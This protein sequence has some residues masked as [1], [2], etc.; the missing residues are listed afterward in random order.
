M[1][2]TVRKE[3]GTVIPFRKHVRLVVNKENQ[4]RAVQAQRRD[5]R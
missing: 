3:D 2:I 5:K 1:S 4:A